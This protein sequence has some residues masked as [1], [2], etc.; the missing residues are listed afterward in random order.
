MHKDAMTTRQVAE[1]LE[2]ETWRIQRLF[3]EHV[4]ADVP[5]FAGKRM[6]PGT[7][8][9]Q[10]IDALRARNW[11]TPVDAKEVTP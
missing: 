8:L 5:R 4:V 9:P 2:V 3:E 10:I 6:I 11:M 7:M 1:L